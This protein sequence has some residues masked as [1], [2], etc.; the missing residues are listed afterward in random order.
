MDEQ[1]RDCLEQQSKRNYAIAKLQD[2]I[3][4]MRAELDTLRGSQGDGNKVHSSVRQL[5]RV[6]NA[7]LQC[8]QPI[9][10]PSGYLL[11]ILCN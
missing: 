2:D 5:S 10:K 8:A 3:A 1:L 4:S 9:D 7:H 11:L 6:F